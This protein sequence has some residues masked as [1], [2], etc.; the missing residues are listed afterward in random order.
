[1]D[2][3]DEWKNAIDAICRSREWHS[4]AIDKNLW[5]DPKDREQRTSTLLGTAIDLNEES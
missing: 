4:N 5:H 1:M 3:S 2:R